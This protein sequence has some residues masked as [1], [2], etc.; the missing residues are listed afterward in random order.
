M[1][2]LNVALPTLFASATIFA[3]CNGSAPA[4]LS[5]AGLPPD[6]TA[7]GTSWMSTDAKKGSLLYI[8]GGSSYSGDVYVFSYPK[9]KLVG[10]IANVAFPSGMCVDKAQN[11][12]V[13]QLDGPRDI[14][15]YK[16]GGTSPIATL[17]D[18]EEFPIGCSVDPTTGNLAV[19]NELGTYGSGSVSIYIGATGSPEGPYSD[20]AFHEIWFCGYDNQG[21]LFIDGVNTSG[22]FEFAELPKGSSQFTN[23]TLDQRFRWPGGIQWDGKY[24]AVGDSE[25]GI[26]YQTNGSGGQVIGSTTLEGAGI[27][28]QFFIERK[29]VIAPNNGTAMF[30]KYP[31]GG[32]AFKTIEGITQQFGAVVSK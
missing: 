31:K 26:I 25:G 1:R 5:G 21:N 28:D 3:G 30:F 32:E 9:G 19:A 6:V 8:S 23:I 11:V 14:L 16:H 13:T 7:R 29:T 12:F 22:Q 2:L 17:D 27:V 18:P 24:V 4:A 10:T 15:E 20:S